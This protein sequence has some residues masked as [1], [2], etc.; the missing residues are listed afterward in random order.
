MPP[1]SR[2]RTADPGWLRYEQL[3]SSMLTEIDPQASIQHNIK[4]EGRLSK[5]GRQIDVWAVGKVAGAE[6]TV[7]VECKK[8]GRVVTVQTVD[9]FVGKLLDIGADRGLL[10]SSSGFT[11]GAKRRAASARNP[12][13]TTY[14]VQD[15][16]PLALA[17]DLRRMP[18]HTFERHVRSPWWLLGA[19]SIDDFRTWLATQEWPT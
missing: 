16:V 3:I 18:A 12:A 10:Y 15:A 17:Y 14:E 6:M 11:E 1:R 7:A 19:R 2:S 4:V 13:V 8:H 5:I 9:Q